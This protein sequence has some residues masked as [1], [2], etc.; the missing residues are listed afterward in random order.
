M[1]A[2]R[3]EVHDVKSPLCCRRLRL[4]LTILHTHRKGAVRNI[5]AYRTALPETLPVYT[6]ADALFHAVDDKNLGLD[7]VIIATPHRLHEEQSISAMKRGLH[8]LC[9]KPAGIYSRQARLMEEARPEDLVC[10]YI[11][12]QRT[13]PSYQHIRRIIQ[14]GE[15]GGLKRM[16]WT[17]TDWYRSN[18]YY[19]SS[20]WRGTWKLDGVRICRLD[21]PE[22]EYRL[23]LGDNFEMPAGTW[24]GFPMETEPDAYQKILQNFAAAINSGNREGLTAPWEEARKSLLISNAI[25]LSSWKGET[26]G[27]PVPG[28]DEELEF[29]KDFENHWNLE[30]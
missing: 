18:A 24:E 11:F 15:L 26:I 22:K 13:Y 25:Y 21:R 4:A 7:A 27:I 19:Q 20:S 10:A 17:V 29:E 1:S 6:S 14:S 23:T 3:K 28:S 12:H 2:F 5:R 8:V 16:N 9:D 30:I